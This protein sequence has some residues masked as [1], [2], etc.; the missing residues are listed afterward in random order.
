MF[1]DFLHSFCFFSHLIFIV[2]LLK[3]F[4]LFF[5]EKDKS[6]YTGYQAEIS[7]SLEETLIEKMHM[8]MQ[9]K[10]K[11]RQILLHFEVYKFLILQKNVNKFFINFYLWSSLC[12][13]YNTKNF[14][15]FRIYIFN[16]LHVFY[17]FCFQLGRLNDFQ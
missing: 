13:C 11:K 2:K 5:S 15:L 12:C 16:N 6:L 7:F 1:F 3:L 17:R 9:I 4:F 14:I 10:V 8:A